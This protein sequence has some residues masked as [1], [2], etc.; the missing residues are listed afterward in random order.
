MSY[1]KAQ[2]MMGR[3]GKRAP[4][5]APESDEDDSNR[6]ARKRHEGVKKKKVVSAKKQIEKDA[7]L[8]APLPVVSFIQRRVSPKAC[9]N[10]E[11]CKK[12]PCGSCN[13]CRHNASLKPGYRA[14]DKRRCEALHCVRTLSRGTG[15]G[16]SVDEITSELSKVCVEL[17]VVGAT[18]GSKNFDQ[19]AYDALITRKTE[20]C[21]AKLAAQRRTRGYGQR[22]PVG[23]N[24]VWGVVANMERA[25]IKFAKFVV[26]Q[27]ISP[28]SRTLDLKRQMRDELDIMIKQFMTRFGES[29]APIDEGEHY[30][31]IVRKGRDEA[32][33]IDS[34]TEF[35]VVS[36]DEN[37]SDSD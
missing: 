32:D 26:K 22:K 16:P 10:C 25:R 27:A 34:D 7:A 30:W 37:S 14:R 13:A 2:P 3:G 15:E 11:E 20:L 36:D 35:T 31:A 1:T 33:E 19:D 28:D 5:P 29:L 9:G 18:R 24:D 8:V 6:S 21:T 17:S 4:A 12:P 23:F